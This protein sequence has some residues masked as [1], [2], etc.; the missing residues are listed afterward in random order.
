MSSILTNTSAM[1]ALQTLKSVNRSLMDTQSQISTGKQVASARDNSAVWAIS[2]S[3]DSDVKGF[4]AISESLAL[5][6]STVAV[7][8]NAAETTTDL[9]TEIKGRIV[10]AQESNVDRTKIQTDIDQLTSQINTVV[11]AAQFNGLNLVKGTENVD[12]LASLDRGADGGVSASNISVARQDLT[13]E[14][15][16]YGDEGAKNVTSIV[17]AGTEIDSTGE[18]NQVVLTFA[19]SDNAGQ[20]VMNISGEEVT[21]DV[22]AND[23]DTAANV[24]AA[25]Q[26]KPGLDGLTFDGSGATVTIRNTNAFTDEAFT[27]EGSGTAAEFEW[28]NAGEGADSTAATNAQT[29]ITLDQRAE[30][31]QFASQTVNSGDS[32]RVTLGTGTAEETFQY[33]AG[34]NETME[35][36]ARGLKLAV[37]AGNYEGVT[38]QVEDAGNGAWNLLIDNDASGSTPAQLAIAVADNTGGVAS[39]GLLGLDNIDVTTNAGA[40]AALD[41]IETLIQNSI[42]ASAAFGSAEGRIETQSGFVSKLMDSLKSGIGALVDADMEEAS[43]RLQA[44]QVQQQLA[45]QSLSIAN[46]AP[47]NILALFR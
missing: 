46:Q 15:G 2:K 24:L 18:D 19:S 29:S 26:A 37:D 10:A 22:G 42:D 11:N 6:E 21:A 39:G 43:A 8:R 27:I 28:T 47:Q 32:F 33:V 38:T 12:I 25:L 40:K 23:N 45:T 4:Q 41:N 30:A 9:L 7:A 44:L 17:G 34:E 36:V 14:A 3:M 13:A 20:I 5:G 16:T 35:D 1:V 31:V